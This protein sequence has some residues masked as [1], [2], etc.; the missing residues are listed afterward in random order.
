MALWRFLGKVHRC[1]RYQDLKKYPVSI[2][3][4]C[5]RCENHVVSAIRPEIY[6]PPL[7]VRMHT[8]VRWSSAGSG[9]GAGTDP[10]RIGKTER[11]ASVCCRTAAF[12]PGFSF[13]YRLK[14]LEDL[15]GHQRAL[16]NCRE[17]IRRMGASQT[18]LQKRIHLAEMAGRLK[19]EFAACEKE[20]LRQIQ[21]ID[22]A[23]FIVNFER[24][25]KGKWTL[26]ENTEREMI[27]AMRTYKINAH[28]N[29]N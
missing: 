25:R 7:L 11:V 2:T 19:G 6:E 13:K 3:K 17:E 5:M 28:S 29:R 26:E 15:R 20:Y 24:A 18:M 4:E 21:D 12:C 27:N 23:K 22:H 9:S 16:T 8:D 10:E 1:N 14:A